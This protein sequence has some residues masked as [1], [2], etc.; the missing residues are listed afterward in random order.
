MVRELDRRPGLTG[1]V[2]LLARWRVAGPLGWPLAWLLY[3]VVL[4]VALTDAMVWYFYFRGAS[5]SV[6]FFANVRLV[7]LLTGIHAFPGLAVLVLAV[8]LGMAAAIA[9]PEHAAFASRTDCRRRAM[10]NG[11]APARSPAMC[12]VG[13]V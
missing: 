5:F 13:R 7:N 2:T 3:V 11:H 1:L 6:R 9:F 4:I 12:R 8:S 10:T